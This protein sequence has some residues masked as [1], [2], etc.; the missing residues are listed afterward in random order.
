MAV[1]NSKKSLS[2]ILLSLLA[3]AGCE[4][5][6]E[7]GKSLTDQERAYLR[8]RAALKCI[9]DSD[10]EIERFYKNSNDRMLDYERQDTWEFKYSKGDTEVDTSHVYVW[11]VSPPNVYFR[12]RMEEG[13]TITNRFLKLDTTVNEEMLIN[14]QKKICSKNLDSNFNS[15]KMTINIEDPRIN[16]DSETES[17]SE[18]D[19][20]LESQYP[21]YFGVMNRKKTKRFYKKTNRDTVTKTET[22]DYTFKRIADVAQPASYNNNTITNREYCVVKFTAA[23]PVNTYDFPFAL[24]CTSSD[25]AGPTGFDPANEL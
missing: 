20:R 6:V 4:E 16:E 1:I 5:S 12:M 21:V 13:G 15:S 9:S 25:T 10:R 23:T 3:F 22:F 14:I 8:E 2:L 19:Y 18:I 17:Q 7:K 24:E 11:K